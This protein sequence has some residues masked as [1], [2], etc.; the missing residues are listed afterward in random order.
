MKPVSKFIRTTLAGGILFMI[1]LVII[2]ALVK[3]SLEF[4]DRATAPLTRHMHEEIIWGLDGSNLVGI[5]VLL[6][7]CFLCGLLFRVASIQ[8]SINRLEE[9]FLSYVPGYTLLKSL[10]SEALKETST[11]SM[12]PVF[13][14]EEA[15]YRPGFL[16]EQ[17]GKLCTVFLPEAPQAN[18]GEL[19]IV[20]DEVVIKVALGTNAMNH[21]IRNLGKGMI[22]FIPNQP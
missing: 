15:G 14:K 13:V 16:I 2:A 21:L 11:H 17:K 12:V 3:R 18:T 1:P 9:K 7:L 4:V 6:I 19:Q 22:D 8:T 10:A 20:P 5:S